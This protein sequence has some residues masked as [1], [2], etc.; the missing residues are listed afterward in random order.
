MTQDNTKQVRR[1]TNMI[2]EPE[3]RREKEGVR[4]KAKQKIN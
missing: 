4:A 1:R 2:L 3:Q